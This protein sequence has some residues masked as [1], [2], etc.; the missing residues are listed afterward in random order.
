VVVNGRVYARSWGVSPDGWYQ[1]FVEDP[2]GAIRIG[3]REIRVRAIQVRGDRVR[4]K[5]EEGYAKKFT[6][7]ASRKW[8]R[9]FKTPRRRAAT[10][11]F[12][13]R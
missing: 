9:G 4:D 11:E 7:E 13:P 6:T 10:L 12:V 8:V 2:D 1:A 3:E 5:V